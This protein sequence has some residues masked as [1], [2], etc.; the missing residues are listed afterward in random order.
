MRRCRDC[1]TKIQPPSMLCTSCK[2]SADEKQ[3]AKDREAAKVRDKNRR[4]ILRQQPKEPK[5]PHQ[6]MACE[7]MVTGRQVF[8]ADCRYKRRKA[9]MKKYKK[10]KK[11]YVDPLPTEPPT[12]YEFLNRM[13]AYL[14]QNG[15]SYYKHNR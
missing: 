10:N 7:N 6:C 2:A 13:N 1:N 4:I 8:C 12:S 14:K 11:P 15:G 5:P 3:R 9:S